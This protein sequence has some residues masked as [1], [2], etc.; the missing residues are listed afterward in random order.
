VKN[1]HRPNH[2]I[3]TGHQ[4]REI[5]LLKAISDPHKLDAYE[6]IFIRRE[7]PSSL[8]GD[9][10]P[11]PYS[12]LYGLVAKPVYVPNRAR[13]ETDVGAPTARPKRI[14]QATLDQFLSRISESNRH[15]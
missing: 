4:L 11:I 14:K 6:S 3:E 12:D 10:G 1:L 9:G 2:C 13:R 15:D 7:G 5:N 8:N